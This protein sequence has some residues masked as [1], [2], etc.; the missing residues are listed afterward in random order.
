LPKLDNCHE[1]IVRALSKDS[2]IISDKPKYV[3]DAETEMFV[4]IDIEA[5]MKPNGSEAQ[6]R[7]IYVEVKCFPGK[8]PSQEVYIALGQYLTYRALLK[9]QAILVPLF[10]AIPKTVHQATIN[11]VLRQALHDNHIMLIVVDLDREV[12]V[13]WIE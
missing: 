9:R 4:Y 12:I 10:L 6:T 1:Q 7:L 13:E 2:W 11:A 3:A 5:H 8:N